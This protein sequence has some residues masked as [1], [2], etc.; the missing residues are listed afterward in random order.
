MKRA[1]SRS[2]SLASFEG[3]G[4]HSGCL[5][6]NGTARAVFDSVG[7]WLPHRRRCCPVFLRVSR[8][9]LFQ[10]Q[11]QNAKLT[12]GRSGVKTSAHQWLHMADC[13]RAHGEK[14]YFQPADNTVFLWGRNLGVKKLSFVE[15]LSVNIWSGQDF[16]LRFMGDKM[17]SRRDVLT[18]RP[19]LAASLQH[20][21][22]HKPIT[23][24]Q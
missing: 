15:D 24:P 8:S 4:R 9:V 10:H 19:I 14:C 18:L 3:E 5:F 17:L 1:H 21:S 22:C 12:L 11:V 2:G 20:I 6:E 16:I 23:A 7:Y 13:I